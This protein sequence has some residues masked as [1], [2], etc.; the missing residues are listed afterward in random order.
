[1]EAPVLR[2]VGDNMDQL[3]TYLVYEDQARVQV[4]LEELGGIQFPERCADVLRAARTAVAAY[5]QFLDE[6]DE[7]ERFTDDD[8]Q[9]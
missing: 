8:A 6:I 4:V 9:T 2:S 7:R 5:S 3:S 1:M